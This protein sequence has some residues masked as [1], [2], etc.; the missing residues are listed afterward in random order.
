MVTMIVAVALAGGTLADDVPL[1]TAYKTKLE[2]GGANVLRSGVHRT[3][4]IPGDSLNDRLIREHE[5]Q[6]REQREAEQKRKGSSYTGTGK[7]VEV[8]GESWENCVEFAKRIT[9]ISRS[10]G[11]GG[12]SGVEGSEPRVG[13]IGVEA[14]IRHAVVVEKIEGDQITITEANFYRGKITRRRLVKSDFVGFIY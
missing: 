12:R 8:I 2:L 4:F 6:L 10:I 3:V 5:R 14:R 11:N 1:R 7:D 13:A 9:G